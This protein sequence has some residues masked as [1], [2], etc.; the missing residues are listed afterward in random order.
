LPPATTVPLLAEADSYTFSAN[1]GQTVAIN[2]AG[3]TSTTA[4]FLAGPNGTI[5]ANCVNG[6]TTLDVAST[7]TYT[8]GVYSFYS[9]GTGTY[10]LSL[11]YTKLVP[12][13]YRLAIGATNGVAALT[14]WGQVG[15]P[16]TLQYA[17]NLVAPVQW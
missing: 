14:I 1:A 5:I 7:G 17:T 4:A 11:S 6:V 16:T 12:A 15:R 13:S 9:A 2:A 10:S 8:V 3:N